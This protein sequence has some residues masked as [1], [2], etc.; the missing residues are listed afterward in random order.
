MRSLVST[1]LINPCSHRIRNK[2]SGNEKCKE[3]I[4]HVRDWEKGIPG[5]RNKAKA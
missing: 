2:I 3:N 5:R 1:Y 4:K